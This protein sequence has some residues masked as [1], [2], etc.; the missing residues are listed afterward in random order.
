MSW[1]AADIPDLTGRTAVVTGANGGLGL[2]T[3]RA[4]AGAGARVVVAARNRAKADA[5][6]QDIR[7]SHPDALL[8]VVQ[9][10]LASQASVKSAAKEILSSHPVV[11]ILINNAGVMALPEG[12]TEDGYETQFGVNHLGHWTLTCLLL[13]ALLRAKSARVVSVSSMARFQ[14]RRLDPDNVHLEDQ[15]D[16]WRAYGNSKL[17]NYVFAQTLER[18]FRKHG[19]KAIS[20]VVHPGLSHTDLQ[21]TADERG[22][23]G[24]IG[25]FWRNLAAKRGMPP[26]RGALP[27]LRAATDPKAKGGQLYAPRFMASGAPVRRP[28]LRPRLRKAMDTL[29][30]VSERETGIALDVEG[31]LLAP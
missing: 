13:P 1:T 15:Y 16:P 2:E 24:R 20:L 8:E 31:V 19:A 18:E 7:R 27:Q 6:A 17:A 3:A 26:V 10:D 28:V 11:D 30:E 9:L 14:G 5:A 23:A 29:M 4:L 22:G 21:V 12:R 25:R